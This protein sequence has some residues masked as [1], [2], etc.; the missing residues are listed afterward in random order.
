MVCEHQKEAEATK[1]VPHPH[2]ELLLLLLGILIRGS[3]MPVLRYL[4]F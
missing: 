4:L 2:L 3:K 1:Q